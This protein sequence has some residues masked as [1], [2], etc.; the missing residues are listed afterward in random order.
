MLHNI[1]KKDQESSKKASEL[2]QEAV[3]VEKMVDMQNNLKKINELEKKAEMNR[4]NDSLANDS[5]VSF[6]ELEVPGVGR[7]VSIELENSSL[8][9]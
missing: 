3:E 1:A 7:G 6:G 9:S 8:V 4:I 2:K 5:K